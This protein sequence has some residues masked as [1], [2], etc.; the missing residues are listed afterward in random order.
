MSQVD[1][2]APP[3]LQPLNYGGDPSRSVGERL[4]GLIPLAAL[5]AIVITLLGIAVSMAL[6]GIFVAIAG[7]NPFEVYGLMYKGAFGTSFAWGNTLTRAAP[8]LLAGLCTALPAR[9]GMV[10]IGGEGALVVGGLTAAA[11]ATSLSGSSP[12]LVLPCMFVAGTIAGGFWI[13]AAGAL[14]QFRG[15]NETISSLLLIYIAIALLNHMVDK[16]PLWDPSSLN[17]PS[18]HFIGD[19]NRIGKLPGIDVHY[20][21]VLGVVACLICLVLM[22]HTTLGF[23][24]SIVGGNPRT[25]KMAGLSITTISLT[26]CFLAGA[27]AG[28]A[29]V[30]E[31]SAVHG[32]ANANLA[33]GYGY[34]GILVAFLARHNPLAIIPVAVLIGGISAGGGR[35]QKSLGMP[36]ATSL[37]F[38]GILFLVVLVFETL[39]GRMKLFQRR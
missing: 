5:E 31:V 32:R 3:A 33:A 29:G 17:N 30:I 20:G 26:V 7:Y 4:L 22:D 27:A 21:L 12:T 36:D 10:I 37:V 25:A 15:V 8:L 38:Q 9:L 1:V 19:G 28:T 6:F 18:S 34:T 14:K 23:A 39:Y 24:A 2:N 16:G 11:V 13:T 35:L